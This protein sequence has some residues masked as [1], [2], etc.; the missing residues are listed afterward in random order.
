MIN[1]LYIIKHMLINTKL[2]IFMFVVIKISR[3]L[4]D[5]TKTRS[6][7]KNLYSFVYQTTKLLIKYY[8]M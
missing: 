3:I 4:C 7:N 8:Y 1:I 5:T 6:Y 2:K